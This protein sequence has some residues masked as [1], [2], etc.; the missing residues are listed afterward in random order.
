M[1]YA[2]FQKI[3]SFKNVNGVLPHSLKLSFLPDTTAFLLKQQQKNFRKVLGSKVMLHYQKKKIFKA[4]ISIRLILMKFFKEIIFHFSSF[5]FVFF[6]F[7]FCF[8]FLR[9]NFSKNMV[10][11]LVHSEKV[12]FVVTNSKTQRSFLFF[13]YWL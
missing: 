1:K 13:C 12:K 10:F 4:E 7:C 5:F 6:L 3:C 8:C 9:T 11:G 2:Q